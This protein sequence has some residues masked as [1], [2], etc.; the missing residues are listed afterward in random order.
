MALKLVATFSVDHLSAVVILRLLSDGSFRR[1]VEGP[2]T[3][4]AEATG[5]VRKRLVAA[6]L[7]L[8]VEPRGG[9]F[10]WMQL[11]DGLDAAAVAQAA[12]A[13]NVVPAPGHVFGA[14]KSAWRHSAVQRGAVRP[15]EGL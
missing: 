12:L 13:E 8:W 14:S 10:L 7:T 9:M 6:G 1:N 4:L 5:Q 3:R 2:R 11:P 15:T